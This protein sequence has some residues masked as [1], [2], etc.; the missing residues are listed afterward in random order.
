M[1]RWER[2]EEGERGI[3]IIQ[4]TTKG[5]G[6]RRES[7][8]A[9]A[10]AAQ[11]VNQLHSLVFDRSQVVSYKW[12]SRNFSVS[13]NVAKRLL[14]EFVERHG[15]GLEIIYAIS[16]WSKV[17]PGCYSVQLVPKAKLQEAKADIRDSSMRIYSVQS[18]LP[19]DPAHLWSAEF[20][21]AEELFN[22]PSG[23]NNCL[24]D[25]RF[26]AVS[27]SLMKRN[28][29]GT[30]T[31]IGLPAPGT[32]QVSASGAKVNG[33]TKQETLPQQVNI[34][35]IS[36]KSVAVVPNAAA[37]SSMVTKDV[38]EASKDVK[39]ASA[40]KSTNDSDTSKTSAV[41][42]NKKKAQNGKATGGAL[43]NLWGRASSKPKPSSPPPPTN[44]NNGKDVLP[45]SMPLNADAQISAWEAGG[46]SSEDEDF[47]QIRRIQS[48]GGSGKKRRVVFDMSDDENEDEMF[49]SE[50]V[51]SLASPEPPKQRP[52]TKAELETVRNTGTPQENKDI[53]RGKG[54]DKSKAI[55]ASKS[56]MSGKSMKGIQSG[57]ACV[58]T[59]S[60]NNDSADD[61]SNS[62][63]ASREKNTIPPKEAGNKNKVCPVECTPSDD[64]LVPKAA[65][66]KRKVLK[67]R[68]DERGREVTEVTW[69][70]DGAESEKA[71]D[72]KH[73]VNKPFAV[74][75][76]D[77]KH[78]AA[79]KVPSVEQ[80]HPAKPAAKP[81]AKHTQKGA[82][83]DTRQ[84]NILSFF[85]KS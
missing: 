45:P 7:R 17:E 28:L 80:S 13:S 26:S 83:K 37:Q 73:T 32:H 11:I 58:Q 24:R 53:E 69:E 12:L 77:N 5:R 25:N 60:T 15:D 20:V 54:T 14:Q 48:K 61:N 64:A 62:M 23:D 21:Q 72:V 68:I 36:Q 52:G 84:G 3:T 8:G 31:R 57:Q 18:C 51:I 81:S 44:T 10:D 63:F 47:S 22:Q 16:G 56:T 67:T 75:H 74:A 59:K 35:S 66:K 82:G 46:N 33:L 50:T 40:G 2:R 41:V 19:K 76:A 27:Y 39:E 38:K 29:N 6:Y 79:G 9:M 1:G 43:A 55:S 85:K 30:N 42:G 71:N 65:A 70:I 34:S 49:G 78:L 4:L